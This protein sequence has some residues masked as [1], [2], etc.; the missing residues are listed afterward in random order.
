MF[1]FFKKNRIDKKIPGDYK[2][3]LTQRAYEDILNIIMQ[4]FKEK[5]EP[6]VK[7]ENGYVSTKGEGKKGHEFKYGLDNL[8]RTVAVEPKE[9]WESVIYTH[10]NKVNYD[11]SHMQ[12]Y[13]KDYEAAKEFLKIL[14]KPEDIL[15]QDLGKELVHQIVFPGTCCVLVF[16]YDNKFTYLLTDEVKEWN[17]TTA[18]L[19]KAAQQNIN[20]EDV[21]AHQLEFKESDVE[22][23][24]FFS[25]DFAAAFV[26]DLEQ[27]APFAVGKYG[28]ITAIPTKGT[29]FA[30]PVNDKDILKLVNAMTGPVLKFFNEDP[31]NITPSLYWY[32]NGRF[33]MFPE[34]PSKEK[35]GYV[36]ISVPKNLSSLINQHT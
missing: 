1:N 25:G 24:V 18:E 11:N 17:K 34:T 31:G 20:N 9:D 33:E 35:D 5:G 14:V 8:V 13:K 29:A 21:K 19:F 16:D 26:I 12:Y 22:L 6:V 28:A 4:Y 27:N 7:V 32:Y 2:H 10:F 36:A 23:Y 30:A 15:K 3:L